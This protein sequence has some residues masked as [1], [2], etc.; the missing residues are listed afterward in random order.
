MTD[1]GKGWVRMGEVWMRGGKASRHLLSP[2]CKQQQVT[3]ANSSNQLTKGSC[4]RGGKAGRHSPEAA[5][6]PHDFLSP[7]SITQLG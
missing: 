1:G 2:L 3:C 7:G 5:T 4:G 6:R